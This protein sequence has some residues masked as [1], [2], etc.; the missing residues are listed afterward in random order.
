MVPFYHDPGEIMDDLTRVMIVAGYNITGNLVPPIAAA[1]PGGAVET[2][3]VIRQVPPAAAPKVWFT[4]TFSLLPLTQGGHEAPA[5]G[6][7]GAD[8]FDSASMSTVTLAYTGDMCVTQD[9][10]KVSR[11]YQNPTASASLRSL[12]PYVNPRYPFCFASG[13]V[14]ASFMESPND[15]NADLL[16]KADYSML[17]ESGYHLAGCYIPDVDATGARISELYNADA[18]DAYVSRYSALL[19][20]VVIHSLV[21]PLSNQ[22]HLEYIPAGGGLAQIT[23]HQ[24]PRSVTNFDRRWICTHSYPQLEAYSVRLMLSNELC[25]EGLKVMEKNNINP[26]ITALWYR[27]G[28]YQAFHSAIA[29]AK[30]DV[31][32]SYISGLKRMMTLAPGYKQVNKDGGMYTG[33]VLNP[34]KW[35]IMSNVFGSKAFGGKGN[36][37]V[38]GL[39]SVASEQIR[40]HASDLVNHSSELKELIMHAGR[41]EYTRDHSNIAIVLP[42][43]AARNPNMIPGGFD[44]AGYW[45]RQDFMTRMHVSSAFDTQAKPMYPGVFF[46]NNIWHFAKYKPRYSRSIQENEMTHSVVASQRRHNTHVLR[47]TVRS[48]DFHTGHAISDSEH[49]MGDQ[50]PGLLEIDQGLSRIGYSN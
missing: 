35:T 25:I 24:G 29:C 45:N 20:A 49:L 47:T 43:S 38:I 7:S 15:V 37:P 11:P 23:S 30:G 32:Q 19:P 36:K 33:V 17:S 13:D 18:Y 3:D 41:G 42:Y 26:P 8:A 1:G 6:G 21:Y 44:V 48:W 12:L 22:H 39:S 34:S 46:A 40:H 5:R 9:G 31:M 2:N 4:S 14:L 27:I 28:E 16:A 10:L 50:L